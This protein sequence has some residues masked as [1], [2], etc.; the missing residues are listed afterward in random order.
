[1]AYYSDDIIERVREASDIVEV[2][3]EFLPLKRKGRSYWARCPFHEEKTASFHVAP[4]KQIFHCFGCQKGGNVFTFVMDHEKLP[5]PEALKYLA[6]RAHIELPTVEYRKESK[7]IEKLYY[8]HEVAADF[9]FEHL[10]DSTK[11]LEYLRKR[12][13]TDET[14]EKFRLGYAPEGWDNLMKY[15]HTKSLTDDD[16]EK[17]G[18][19]VRSEKDS[20]YDRFRDRLVF[21]IFN[22]VSKPIAFG[23]RALGKDESAKYI[24]SPET[25]LYQ[26]ARVLYGLSHS[27][28]EIRKA[29]EAI[30]VEG[31]FDFL[32]L[33]Q[34]GIRNVVAS[35]GTAFTQ[36]QAQLLG[37]SA[38]SVVLMFDADSAGQ[39]AALRSVDHLFEAGIEV[40]VVALPE[41]EDPDSMMREKGPDVVLG[42]IK[43]AQSFVQFSLST[44]PD[45]YEKLSLSMKDKAIKR[46]TAL[47]GKLEDPIKRELFVQDISKWY[48]MDVDIVRRT[49][50]PAHDK[51]LPKPAAQHVSRLEDDFLAVLL[52]DPNMIDRAVARV[53]PSDFHADSA[54]DI[55]RLMLMLYQENRAVDAAHLIDMVEGDSQKRLIAELASQPFEGE[56]PEQTLEDYLEAF[57]RRSKK[58]RLSALKDGLAQAERESDQGKID[59]YLAEISRLRSEQ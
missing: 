54:A 28:N 50:K 36:E 9:F 8:A 12:K 49:V 2:I 22:S 55:Y 53:S 21:T 44:L 45:R 39:N 33:Y 7:E 10:K 51:P 26:K 27:R 56:N 1:M 11:T 6:K 34:G 46:L 15:A 38:A 35:S 19:V 20:L 14:I 32:S 3:S 43:N 4:D 23:A 40:K 18:L 59:Y 42:L 5:F 58:I 17:A 57:N 37:R 48:G 41:G 47:A 16:L 30:V 13:L 29:E 52:H 25:P 31:Y 24:N